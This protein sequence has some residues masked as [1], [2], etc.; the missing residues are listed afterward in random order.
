MSA[1][2]R[3]YVKGV[4]LVSARGNL[5]SSIPDD[6]LEMK[7]WLASS[8]LPP[9]RRRTF[10][11]AARRAAPP[12]PARP[13]VARGALFTTRACARR[14]QT[15]R[16]ARAPTGVCWPRA[17]PRRLP[18]HLTLPRPI[19]PHS[20]FPVTAMITLVAVL[21]YLLY[22]SRAYALAYVTIYIIHFTWCQL[23]RWVPFVHRLFVRSF[24]RALHRSIAA[25]AAATTTTNTT[26][27]TITTT[28]T[29]ATTANPVSLRPPPRP[30]STSRSSR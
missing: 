3:F 8:P 2:M 5:S 27:T 20:Q 15:R 1:C 26:N 21:F 12:R 30:R 14:G 10:R 18:P 25:A 29:T 9:G 17:P 19:H 28:T 11:C 16:G 24:A 22:A 13:P 7:Y 6:E 23:V 4:H